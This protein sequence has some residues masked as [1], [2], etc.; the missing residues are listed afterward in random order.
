MGTAIMELNLAQELASI[1]QSPLLLVF[2]DLRKAFDIVD[3]ARLLMT[4]EGY[5]AGP[6]LCGILE[7]FLS[8]QQL[9]PRLN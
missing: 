1:D 9:E 6:R 5:G 4:P 8:H 3:L 2:L 7:N